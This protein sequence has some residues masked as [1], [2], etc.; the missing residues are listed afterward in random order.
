MD[1]R[2]RNVR[3][4]QRVAGKDAGGGGS[5][6]EQQ[7]RMIGGRALQEMS[8]DA[9]RNLQPTPPNLD[10]RPRWTLR[11]SLSVGLP[12]YTRKG[13]PADEAREKLTRRWFGVYCANVST[14]HLKTQS[15]NASC[16]LSYKLK[17]DRTH[18][19]GML[20]PAG[21]AGKEGQGRGTR[22]TQFPWIFRSLPPP[23]L[24]DLAPANI[25]SLHTQ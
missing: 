19:Y 18:V 20:E 22:P 14:D 17:T 11:S 2:C 24:S 6:S 15:E 10:S 13:D 1:Y 4:R 25:L 16:S 5:V 12:K 3:F 23:P 8:F 7:T 9:I 21:Q